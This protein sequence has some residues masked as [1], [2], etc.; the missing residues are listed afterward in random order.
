[1]DS[2]GFMESARTL[3]GESGISVA[4]GPAVVAQ[5]LSDAI[6]EGNWEQASAVMH[7]ASWAGFRVRSENNPP[8]SPPPF[9]LPLLSPNSL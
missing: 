5:Q 4:D 8:N 2:L 3:E 7:D 6:L 1:M 9:N